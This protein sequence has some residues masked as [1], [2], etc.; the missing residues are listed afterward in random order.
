MQRLMANFRQVR[1]ADE[2]PIVP[3]TAAVGNAI[4]RAIGIRMT[5]LPVSPPKLSEA[6]DGA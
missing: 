6:I 3:P 4:S 2:V 1:G 5:E